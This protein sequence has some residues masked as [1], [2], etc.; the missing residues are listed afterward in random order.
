MS[1]IF[2]IFFILELF[3][4]I[5]LCAGI[6]HLDKRVN[7]LAEKFKVNRHTL[8]FKL[9]AVYDVASTFKC[10]MK[11]QKREFLKRRRKFYRNLIKGALVGILL[12]FFKKTKF[13]KK[14]LLAELLLVM[15]DTFRADCLA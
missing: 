12:F 10:Q 15:Y 3:A 9:R 1:Y 11:Q 6:M 2:V 7:S 4:V 14:I 13:K 8:K 5:V